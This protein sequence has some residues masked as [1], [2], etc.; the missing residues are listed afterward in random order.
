MLYC[1]SAVPTSNSFMLDQL[2]KLLGERWGKKIGSRF[3]ILRQLKDLMN[4]ICSNHSGVLCKV[5]LLDLTYQGQWWSI[6][7][8]HLPHTAR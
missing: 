6:F 3:Q 5:H 8:T 4:Q 1:I 2:Q 7:S